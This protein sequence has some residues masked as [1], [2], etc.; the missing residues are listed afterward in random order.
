MRV[1]LDL[2]VELVARLDRL[3]RQAGV[4]R[5]ELVRRA[6]R[7]YLEHMAGSTARIPPGRVFGL[8][9]GRGVDG[10]SYQERMRDGRE[11]G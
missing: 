8:W 7:H 9:Q 10:L 2:P 6:V 3:R 5:A 11:G 1:T 4:S